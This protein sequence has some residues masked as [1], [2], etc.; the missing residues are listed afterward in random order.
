MHND[1]DID[2]LLL[3]LQGVICFYYLYPRRRF[4]CRWALRLLPFQ[5]VYLFC[6]FSFCYIKPLQPHNLK[7]S[8]PHNLKTSQT[9]NLITS[10]PYNLTT[11]QPHNLLLN[12]YRWV[13]E[14][15]VGKDVEVGWLYDC[16]YRERLAL[17]KRQTCS[18][19]QITNL[20]Q[21]CCRCILSRR[22]I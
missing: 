16:L 11:S 12:H 18:C 7:T 10:Q 21:V 20:Y 4:A 2:I 19:Q 14:V 3:P 8:Q 15:F 1:C 6:F 22:H 13:V 5:G 9:H 17:A